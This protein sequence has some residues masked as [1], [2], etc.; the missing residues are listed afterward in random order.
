M[1][2]THHR[3]EIYHDPENPIAWAELGLALSQTDR[4]EAARRA[5][6]RAIA[7]D[8]QFTAAW[9]NLGGWHHDRQDWATALACFQRAI[10]LDPHSVIAWR[11][12]GRAAAQLQDWARAET[13]FQQAIALDPDQL[14]S[15]VNLGICYGDRN[16]LD[17][18]LA[19]YDAALARRPD[20]VHLAWNRSLTLLK[21]GRLG[22]GWVAYESR[23]AVNGLQRTYPQPPWDGSPLGGKRVLIYT[24]QGFGDTIQFARYLDGVRDRGGEVILECPRNLIRLLESLPSVSHCIAQGDPLPPFATHA[25]L[26][27]LPRILGTHTLADIPAPIPYLKVP[28]AIAH[29]WHHH[30]HLTAS[31]VPN[32]PKLKVGIV[33]AS[34][35]RQLREHPR[36]WEIYQ[37]KS[38]PL[39]HLVR[40]IAHPQIQLYSLQVGDDAEDLGQLSQ[41]LQITRDPR[42]ASDPRSSAPAILDLAPDLY[43]FAETAGAIQALDGVISV[44]TAV[45]HLAGALGKPVWVLLPFAADWRWLCDRPDSPW[46]PTMRLV[47]QPAIGDWAGALQTL[48]RAIAPLIQQ[49]HHHST[50]VG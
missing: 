28:E 24:E 1:I 35:R 34:G 10:A 14:A 46:Y 38:C 30:P 43:D 20:W 39:D 17:A 45:A 19:V 41:Q 33:W 31:P 42:F 12:G 6:E 48:Q 2:L 3:A 32:L 8:P 16:L 27:S 36:L 25:A 18:E 26:L 11:N 47:R 37:Q 40:A 49:T 29:R 44:D 4:P 50:S 22:E 23:W 9:I 5:Y 21:L 13:Y 15:Q 7:L